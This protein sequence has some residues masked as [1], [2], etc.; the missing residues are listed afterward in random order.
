MA[1]WAGREREYQREWQR[2]RRLDPL[3][4]KSDSERTRRWQKRHPLKHAL[5]L[6][7]Q[8][9]TR[10]G[11]CFTLDL[12]LFEDLVTDRCFYCGAPPNPLNGVDRVVNAR[13][14]EAG[15]VVSAC[16]MCNRAKGTLSAAEF[17]GWM[18]RLA[19]RIPHWAGYAKGVNANGR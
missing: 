6:Y 9:A 18:V 13:G 5:T 1:Q 12:R 2:L 4:R 3:A 16:V 17:E 14:Y 8:S 7:R 11:L 10:R 15:N 19:Q